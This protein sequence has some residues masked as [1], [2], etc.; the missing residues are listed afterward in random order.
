MQYSWLRG[1]SGRHTPFWQVTQDALDHALDAFGRSGETRL[2]QELLD[3]Y[4]QLG[5]Y[6]EV[7]EMLGRLK[8][9]GLRTAILSNGSRDMLD[10]AVDSAGIGGLL[11]AVIS[12]DEVG[13]FKPHPSVYDLPVR[14][15]GLAPDRMSFQSSNGWDAWS[16]SAHG[17]RVVWV[18]RQGQA[19]E[20]LPGQPDHV[21]RDLSAL[22]RLLG[23]DT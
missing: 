18:N 8:A 22:P 13:V 5:V 23:L 3:L 16:A 7:A 15:F 17:Y 21:V 19:P 4:F 20:R 12:V 11:D 10:A 2:R 14:A 9:A 6:P 1:L